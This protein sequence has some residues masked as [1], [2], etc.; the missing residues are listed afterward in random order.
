[1]A[2]NA[3]GGAQHPL[4]TPCLATAHS[5]GI[6]LHGSENASVPAQDYLQMIPVITSHTTRVLVLAI[7]YNRYVN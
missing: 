5:I 3:N 6:G 2:V 1:M 4:Y 7:L